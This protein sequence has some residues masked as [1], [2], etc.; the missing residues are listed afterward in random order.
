MQLYY[1]EMLRLADS[2]LAD[3]A[4]AEDA[5]QE[6]M[7]S[8]AL[9]L[10]RFLGQA[11][12]KTWLYS[13]VVNTCLDHLRRRK[14]RQALA[15]ALQAIHSIFSRSPGLEEAVVQADEQARLWSAVSRL[16]DRQRVPILLYYVHDLPVSEIAAILEVSE[17]TVHSRLFYA[18]KRLLH[19]L[20]E[21][22]SGA[23]DAREMPV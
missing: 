1:A 19:E 21:H 10:D 11:S 16:D 13:I 15:G 6:S 22:N 5:A 12:P 9:A 4:E 2:I 14:R 3:P 20:K 8:A 23:D 18:R 7:I 17:G